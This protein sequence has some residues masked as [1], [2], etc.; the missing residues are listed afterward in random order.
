[1]TVSAWMAEAARER[2]GL[3][4]LAALVEEWEAEHGAFTEEELAEG[5]RILENP[6]E[7][8][9]VLGRKKKRSA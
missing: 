6:L 1:M 4:G 8:S 9:E 7:P 5:R 2:L 3:L